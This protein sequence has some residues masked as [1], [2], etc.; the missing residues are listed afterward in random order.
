MNASSSRSH[1]I[2]TI[3]IQR[4]LG[5]PTVNTVRD[6]RT[7]FTAQL[8][9]ID[10]AGSERSSKVGSSGI[11]ESCTINQSLSALCLVIKAL[12]E[13]VEKEMP[14][15]GAGNGKKPAVPFRASKIT[16][17]MKGA[18]CGNTKSTLI[19]TVT[20]ASESLA[21]TLSTIDFAASVMPLKT[22]AVQ[23]LGLDTERRIQV[24][25]SE[26]R[27]L[28][29][30]RAAL[31]NLSD[32]CGP[33]SIQEILSE[34]LS[35]REQMLAQT[36]ATYDQQQD[37]AIV[38]DRARDEVL[39]GLGLTSSLIDEVFGIESNTPYL[40]NMSSDPVLAGCL[41]YFL[42]PGVNTMIGAS[43]ENNI[44][45][46]GLGIPD[47]LCTLECLDQ[48]TLSLT[49]AASLQEVMASGSIVVKA[50]VRTNGILLKTDE[51][52]RLQHLDCIIFGRAHAMK[53][54]LPV[55]QKRLAVSDVQL[56]IAQGLHEESMFKMLVTEE[57][58]AWNELRLYF[59]DLWQRLGEERGRDFFAWLM[60]ASHLVDEA[61]EITAELRPSDRLKFEVELV[62]D[63]H[64]EAQDIIVIR[65]MQFP[66]EEDGDATVLCYWN[67][68]TLKERV[69]MMRDCFDKFHRTGEW[70][71]RS[72]PLED[73]WMDP[74]AINLRLRMHTAQED[75]VRRY[76]ERVSL[77][78]PEE[79]HRI[80][81]A[82]PRVAST[83][84]SAAG[85]SAVA[86]GASSTKAKYRPGLGNKSSAKP[87]QRP[88]ANRANGMIAQ[89]RVTPSRKEN[90]GKALAANSRNSK[91]NTSDE[92]GPEAA[93][94]G[95]GADNAS[96]RSVSADRRAPS[97][98][99]SPPAERREDLGEPSVGAAVLRPSVDKDAMIA[100]LRQQVEERESRERSYKNKIEELRRKLAKLE[101][102]HGSLKALT[103]EGERQTSLSQ[104]F[105]VATTLGSNATLAGSSTAA[106]GGMVRSQTATGVP[107]MVFSPPQPQAG[108][109]TLNSGRLDAV[110]LPSGLSTLESHPPLSTS[111]QRMSSSRS[112]APTQTE[113]PLSITSRSVTVL[114][115][116][117]RQASAASSF[118]AASHPQ[119]QLR[120]R[121]VA[122]TTSALG[123]PLVPSGMQPVS[124]ILFSGGVA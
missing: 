52:R 63:I 64:R 95:R 83:E 96:T 3:K 82:S 37:D 11:K 18:L 99:R 53:L 81:M 19:A 107:T 24:L 112:S 35:Q 34:E 110:P 84:I 22:F 119:P 121:T 122:A 114:A 71:D 66:T 8:S 111:P 47:F 36:M 10:L 49:A 120:S 90:G 46:S 97:P 98:E 78:D 70:L 72:D 73:P 60:Q 51:K 87:P 44:V 13:Q 65:A 26:I 30:R 40:L 75:I 79:A 5:P 76:D 16:M 113:P 62:W 58:E 55:E 108:R 23:N 17:L 86:R 31:P 92:A 25:Q 106:L 4:F 14:V 2:F 33:S 12:N 104:K 59:D 15:A 39:R 74:S 103:T 43:P 7:V 68:E 123:M 116:P 54:I 115:A 88:P 6:E 56:K 41:I 117:S 42:H 91:R 9:F 48:Q 102:Q 80:E 20:P 94:G 57:S 85:G 28:K 21:E 77:L 118:V 61:N 1:T 69:A 100:S 45:L 27:R 101:R 32:E 124:A 109:P 29:I 67:L 38:A 50:N 93:R 89:E 105:S